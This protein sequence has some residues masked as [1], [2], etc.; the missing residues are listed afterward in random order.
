M[1][2]L[3]LATLLTSTLAAVG[4]AAHVGY[5]EPYSNVDLVYAAPGVQVI[6]DYDEPIFYS[7][8]YYWR[9]SGGGW[10]RSTYYTGGWVWATPP[11]AV[12]RID[13]PH[14]FVHYRPSG[15]VARSRP[16]PPPRHAAPPQGAG[17]RGNPA[18]P[19]PSGGW[20]GNAAAPPPASGGW[21]GNASPPPTRSAPPPSGW[22]GRGH[23]H[24]R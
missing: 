13:R 9:Q 1:R 19:P 11:V 23:G 21:R 10:Y 24:G 6:A 8:G 3:I 4:C 12:V 20:R 15:Y 2:K 22:R 5:T 7:D 14:R 16:V 18:A 17:W